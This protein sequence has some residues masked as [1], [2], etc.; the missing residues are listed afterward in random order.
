MS[1]L[2]LPIFFF[3][4]KKYE[5]WYDNVKVN[6][7]VQYCVRNGKKATAKIVSIE[8]YLVLRY[9]NDHNEIVDEK[10]VSI[11]DKE[12]KCSEE[13]DRIDWYRTLNEN[14]TVQYFVVSETNDHGNPEGGKWFDAI[15]VT[16]QMIYNERLDERQKMRE[17]RKGSQL[18]LHPMR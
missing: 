16:K 6:D 9:C 15:I 17:P 11:D 12:L 5:E 13:R 2:L 14:D 10:S 3:F 7:A 18:F 8:Y 4:K 1:L